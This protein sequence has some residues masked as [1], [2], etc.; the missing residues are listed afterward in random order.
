[1]SFFNTAANTGSDNGE[2]DGLEKEDGNRKHSTLT[3]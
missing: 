3:C 2:S 1:M